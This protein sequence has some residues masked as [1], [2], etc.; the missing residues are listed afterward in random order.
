M[1]AVVVVVG[2]LLVAAAVG[3]LLR[4]REGRVRATNDTAVYPD[5]HDWLVA[6]GTPAVMHFSAPWCGPCAAVR[7]VV[8][9]VVAELADAPLPPRDVE[10]DISAAPE[11]A[12]QHRVLSLPTT[13]ILDASG[14]ERFRITGV[15]RP[16]ELRSALRSLATGE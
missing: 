16:A 8:A 4:Y 7:T 14:A 6:P 15:P 1:T 12:R 5:S 3:L 10:L 9:T 2:V 13:V 11:L